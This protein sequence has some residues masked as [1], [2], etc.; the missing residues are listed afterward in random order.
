MEVWVG[1]NRERRDVFVFAE[2]RVRSACSVV[3]SS[4]ALLA[5]GASEIVEDWK[6]LAFAYC[7]AS[8]RNVDAASIRWK[9]ARFVNGGK[10]DVVVWV[11]MI[12]GGS[13]T[14][15][16]L[17]VDGSNRRAGA[18]EDS[19]SEFGL[20]FTRA[21][22]DLVQ[23][24]PGDDPGWEPLCTSR[25][26]KCPAICDRSEDAIVLADDFGDDGKEV[27]VDEPRFEQHSG[28]F[29]PLVE[30]EVVDDGRIVVQRHLR[31][32][33]L[34]RACFRLMYLYAAYEFVSGAVTVHRAWGARHGWCNA[35]P[36]DYDVVRFLEPYAVVI[37]RNAYLFDVKRA[38]PHTSGVCERAASVGGH[39]AGAMDS[40]E[41][42]S[43]H[44]PT[45]FRS[46]C[47]LCA[48]I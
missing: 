3:S 33:R 16:L 11:P 34:P 45:L 32:P 8:R 23:R 7:V 27:L 40:S 18:R 41:R 38:F 19:D 9:L 12:H 2:F 20:P 36:S 26:K 48:C 31:F 47:T 13:D 29:S 10:A 21:T 5:R 14:A 22:T 24:V 25:W 17:H 35:K 30:E 44:L 1:H 37:Y 42:E 4:E 39:A 15:H 6:P 46:F 28:K 43:A